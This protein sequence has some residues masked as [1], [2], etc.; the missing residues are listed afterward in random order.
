MSNT[1]ACTRCAYIKTD[2][3]LCKKDRLSGK[4]YCSVHMKIIAN[5]HGSNTNANNEDKDE[6]M[7]NSTKPQEQD[8]E[9]VGDSIQTNNTD[10]SKYD[11]LLYDLKITNDFIVR[12]VTYLKTDADYIKK[13]IVDELKSDIN[14]LVEQMKLLTTVKSCKGMHPPQQITPKML[15]KRA[16]TLFYH[17]YKQ[18]EEYVDAIRTGLEK[19]QLLDKGMKVPWMNIRIL[20]D[21]Y[22]NSTL[23]QEQRNVYFEMAKQTFTNI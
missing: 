8:D 9:T 17:E 21:H 11:D 22:F 19:A 7:S 23:T 10:M 13:Q 20:S 15:K 12:T 3:T 16:Q 5:K 1:N 2:G 4:C 14:L 18:K 6:F